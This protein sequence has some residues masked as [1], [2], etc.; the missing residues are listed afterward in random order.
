MINNETAFGAE[1]AIELKMLIE[2]GGQKGALEDALTHVRKEKAALSQEKGGIGFWKGHFTKEGKEHK[3]KLDDALDLV[4]KKEHDYKSVNREVK[5]HD[6]PLAK[7][8]RW[9][10]GFLGRKDAAAQYDAKDADLHKRIQNIKTGQE[11][12]DR[13]NLVQKN[14]KDWKEEAPGISNKAKDAA[15]KLKNTRI[16]NAGIKPN[17]T[18]PVD[19]TPPK[20][21]KE[22]TS[23]LLKNFGT[24]IVDKFKPASETPKSAPVDVPK[25]AAA[26]VEAPKVEAPASTTNQNYKAPSRIIT[27]PMFSHLRAKG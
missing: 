6:R 26:P 11:Y 8:N 3:R 9:L 27:K 7:A 24:K 15:E 21:E 2:I 10:S 1:L 5:M 12:T 19:T 25:P 20:F 22:D 16:E 23:S 13:A 14:L 17:Y 4:K 18:P